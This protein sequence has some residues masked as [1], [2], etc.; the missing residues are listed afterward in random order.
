[1]CRIKVFDAEI[2]QCLV[3]DVPDITPP[4]FFI[5]IVGGD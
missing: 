1:M 2:D 5:L 4:S 3:T